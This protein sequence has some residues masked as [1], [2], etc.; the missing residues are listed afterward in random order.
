M[1]EF[2]SRIPQEE[3]EK[4]ELTAEE[5]FALVEEDI[6]PEDLELMKEACG[7]DKEMILGAIFSYMVEI[8]NMSEDESENYLM[9]K[10]MLSFN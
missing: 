6:S 1:N 8:K 2:E 7:D 10:G 9:S 4:P 5:I 3:T